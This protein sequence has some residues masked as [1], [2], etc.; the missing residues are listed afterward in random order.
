[1]AA[2]V[3]RFLSILHSINLNGFSRQN[4]E[5]TVRANAEP[6]P[7]AFV[8]E[9]QHVAAESAT[10]C[11]HSLPNVATHFFRQRRNC[12]RAFSLISSRYRT[13]GILLRRLCADKP[14]HATYSASF[15]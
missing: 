10:H 4:E 6:I 11:F 12:S 1:M 15:F 8:S 7:I 9:F 3:I 5:N 14:A 13:T 2:S